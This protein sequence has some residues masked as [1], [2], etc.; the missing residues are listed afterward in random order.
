MRAM[1][2]VLAIVVIA[3]VLIAGAYAANVALGMRARSTTSGTLAG[4]PVHA[5]VEILR[6]AR[7]VP[8]IRARSRYDLFFVVPSANCVHG[9]WSVRSLS[10]ST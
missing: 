5:P 6:D 4:L 8:H 7:G 3:V 9:S 10:G 1:R 2:R